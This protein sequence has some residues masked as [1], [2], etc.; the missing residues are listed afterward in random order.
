M[1]YSSD[2]PND[3]VTAVQPS[4]AGDLR[5]G[6]YVFVSTRPIG[7]DNVTAISGPT[8]FRVTKVDAFAVTDCD[9]STPLTTTSS[10]AGRNFGVYAP[11]TSTGNIVVDDVVASCYASYGSHRLAHTVMSP[12]VYAR[13][14]VNF[15]ERWLLPFPV[16]SFDT[17]DEKSS[18]G[19]VDCTHWYARAL[20]TVTTALGPRGVWYGSDV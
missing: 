14:F 1:I 11:L 2:N 4:F 20:R 9:P 16:F 17:C 19:D 13:R 6:S 18:V 7:A 12:L 8:S 10:C 15:A 3:D 5:V